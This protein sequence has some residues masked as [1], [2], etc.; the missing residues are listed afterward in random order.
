MGRKMQQSSMDILIMGVAAIKKVPKVVWVGFIAIILLV[1]IVTIISKNQ[2]NQTAFQNTEV[3]KNIPAERIKAYEEFLKKNIEYD[4]GNVSDEIIKDVV[5]REDTYKETQGGE[6]KR[7][8]TNSEFTID[9]DSIGR[10]YDVLVRWTTSNS[11]YQMQD[12]GIRVNCN[13]SEKSKYPNAKCKTYTSSYKDFD[14]SK[15]EENGDK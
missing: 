10:T 6:E 11:E 7:T 9:I 14:N 2:A 5:I 8:Y 4:V 15:K 3:L 13:V 12:V 1:I